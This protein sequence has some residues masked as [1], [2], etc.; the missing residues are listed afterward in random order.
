MIKRLI[1]AKNES[2]TLTIEL[3]LITKRWKIV[4][5]QKEPDVLLIPSGL[6]FIKRFDSEENLESYIQERFK[7]LKY[8]IS[9]TKEVSY[10][11]VLKENQEGIDLELEPFAI[12]RVCAMHIKDGLCL[13]LKDSYLTFVK[14]KSGLLESFRTINVGLDD[15]KT[16]DFSLEDARKRFLNIIEDSGYSIPDRLILF[17]EKS[18]VN[19]AY[20]KDFEIKYAG[21]DPDLIGACLGKAFKDIY[22]RFSQSIFKT[23]EFKKTALAGTSGALLLLFFNFLS[24]YFFKTDGLRDMQRQ[25][26]KKVFPNEPAVSPYR[27]LKSKVSSGEGYLL[28]SLL[29]EASSSLRKGM[30]IYSFEFDSTSLSIKGKAP[31]NLLNGLNPRSVRQVPDGKEFELRFP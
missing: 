11:A 16:L 31:E 30:I 20:F 15:L 17:C 12:A 4:S 1:C 22:P 8:K 24:S 19:T 13:S 23:Q 3:N 21:K 7:D 26:F 14:L 2:K 5:K 25:E 18:P 9:K 29:V 10:I 6:C 28:S 27:Q